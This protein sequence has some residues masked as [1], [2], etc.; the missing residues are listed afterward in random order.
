M[1]VSR[2]IAR[3]IEGVRV[4][5]TAAFLAIGLTLA[6]PAASHGDDP[7]AEGWVG[8][9][10]VQKYNNFPVRVDGRAVPGSGDRFSIY[11]VDRVEGGRLHLEGDGGAVGGWGEAGQFVPVDEAIAFFTDRIRKRPDDVFSH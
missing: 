5:H 2:K 7:A 9:R 4:R 11:R 3:M 10:V 8:K 6:V 1:R